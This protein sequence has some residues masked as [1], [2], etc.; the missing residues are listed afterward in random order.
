MIKRN[1]IADLLKGIAVLLM[2]QVHILELFATNEIYSSHLGKTLLFMGAAPV[3]PLFAII[4]CYFIIS[5]GK[6]KT[7]LITRGFKLIGLGMLLNIALNLNLIIAVVKGNYQIDLLPFIFGFDILHFAGVSS[8]IIALFKNTLQKHI[9]VLIGCII[10][11]A[12][13]GHGL[14]NFIPQTIFLKY[15][16]SIFYGCCEWSYFPIFPWIAYPLTGIAF[17]QLKE[18]YGSVL[19]KVV[20][21]K[22]QLGILFLLFFIFTIKY[23]VTISSDL[24]SYYHHDIIFYLWTIVFITFYSIFI[25]EI[26]NKFGSVFILKYIKWLG[27]NVTVIYV[28]QWILIG[29]TATEIYKTVSQPMQLF[30]YYLVVM[31]LSSVCAYL[32]LKLWDKS[33]RL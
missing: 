7:E 8:I 28:I 33:N 21:Q 29:N 11:A 1:S 13:L 9:L 17:Y 22:L 14:L 19:L 25:N 10:G 5:T 26:G 27:E 31:I 15:F 20:N 12:L 3:A 2:V 16:L 23:A 24:P 18:R 30:Y 6:S 4:L 32:F